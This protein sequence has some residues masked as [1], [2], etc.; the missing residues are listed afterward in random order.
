MVTMRNNLLNTLPFYDF[1][2]LLNSLR[3]F[4]I[5]YYQCKSIVPQSNKYCT[6]FFTN[7]TA[8]KIS[9]LFIFQHYIN[10][11]S[12]IKK[13]DT[14]S[15]SIFQLILIFWL[16]S[17]LS[18][19]FC[20]CLIN[21]AS[22]GIKFYPKLGS[23]FLV[24]PYPSQSQFINCFFINLTNYLSISVKKIY[25]NQSLRYFCQYNSIYNIL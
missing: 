3:F 6:Y 12:Q 18:Q 25:Q 7:L 21:V 10:L 2:S 19:I 14:Y 24:I 15:G 13:D 4:F 17:S 9:F 22:V 16:T 23:T 8:S 20:D 11:C 1:F 5:Q